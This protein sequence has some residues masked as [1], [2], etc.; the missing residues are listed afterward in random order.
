MRRGSRI[1]SARALVDAALVL[2]EDDGAP[3]PRR[4]TREAVPQ[5][6]GARLSERERQKAIM[7]SPLPRRINVVSYNLWLTPPSGA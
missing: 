3:C 6:G 4:Q 2:R 5:G 7:A 1:F